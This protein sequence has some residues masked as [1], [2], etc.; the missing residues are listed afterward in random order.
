M[1]SLWYI[2]HL[3]TQSTSDVLAVSFFFSL[4]FISQ[5]LRWVKAVSPLMATLPPT[6][7][8]PAACSMLCMLN[9]Y[10]LLMMAFEEG[11]QNVLS[12]R[13]SRLRVGGE[14]G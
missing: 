12:Q 11:G 4:S 7:P 13:T 1:I 10:A 3:V 9:K 2:A 5:R 6:C 14:M 8:Q